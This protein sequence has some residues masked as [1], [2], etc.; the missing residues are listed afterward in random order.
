M[1]F[2]DT[3]VWIDFFN[4]KET[5]EVLILEAA[6]GAEVVSIGDLIA[7]EIL[8]GFRNDKDYNTAKEL[9]SALTI[10]SLLGERAAYV[11]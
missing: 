5:R 8:Q 2:V 10:Y 1:I 4:G 6:L 3:S 9:L 11:C 7:L